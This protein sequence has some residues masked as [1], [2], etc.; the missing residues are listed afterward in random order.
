MVMNEVVLSWKENLMVTAKKYGHFQQ[1]WLL[2]QYAALEEGHNSDE[3][4]QLHTSHNTYRQQLFYT[5]LILLHIIIYYITLPYTTLRSPLI[6][7]TQTDFV[8]T[9]SINVQTFFLQFFQHPFIHSFIQSLIFIIMIKNKRG[10]IESPNDEKPT[11][12][13][14]LLQK[15][16]SY[17]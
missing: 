11:I 17:E 16:P 8:N 15:Q 3:K 2:Q 12:K 4:V 7:Y 5:G 9:S 1:Y 6:K 14:L 10:G 13:S